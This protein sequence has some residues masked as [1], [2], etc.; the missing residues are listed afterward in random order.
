[1]TSRGGVLMIYFKVMG[2]PV[3]K[4]RPRMTTRGGYAHAYTPKKTSEYEEKLKFEFMASTSDK[5]PVYEK[6]IPLKV[7]MVMAFAIPK[8]FSKKKTEQA[9]LGLIVPTKKPD[10]DNVIKQLDALN[11]LAFY[12]DSQITSI[13]AEKIYAEEPYLEV[14][15]HP[16]DWGEE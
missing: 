4:G 12:D 6:G 3:G 7:E 15:I 11:G 8:S 5:M 10:V 9:R 13:T 1:M 2:E 14:K 16:R